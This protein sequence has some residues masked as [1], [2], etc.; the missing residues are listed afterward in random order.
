MKS[1]K[2]ILLLTA[3][4]L[5]AGCASTEKRFNK[6]V[7]AEEQ[8]E[9]L[10]AANFYVRVLEKEPGYE[11]AMDHLFTVGMIVIDNGMADALEMERRENFAS[12]ANQM[13][14][15]E[16][17]WIR[18]DRVGVSLSMPDDFEATRNSMEEQAFLQLIDQAET[19]AAAGRW[20][21]S[22]VEYERAMERAEDPDR[23]ARI[24]EA[25]GAVH[26]RWAETHLGLLRFK[27]AFDRAE[28]A[29]QLL[30]PAH[31]ISQQAIALQEQALLDGTRVIAFL[32]LGQTL[33][34]L[35]NNLKER[36]EKFA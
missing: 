28:N 33:S 24:E 15:I 36:G 25:I 8:G 32:P 35:Q 22:I 30:G 26:L 19:A 21:D 6:G 12:A 17:M 4:L 31:P 16:G 13:D 10:K 1:K 7:E 3:F 29:I 20:N 11:P 34:Q 2:Y 9:Y 27:E 5:V 18:A 23:R 14:A